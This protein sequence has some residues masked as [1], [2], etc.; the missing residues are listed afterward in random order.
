MRG[1]GRAEQ[2]GQFAAARGAHHPQP[3]GADAGLS[4]EPVQGG[5]EVFERDVDELPWQWVDAEVRERQGGDAVTRQ[6]RGRRRTRQSP[7]GPREE[8]HGGV[9]P[10]PGRA[11][12]LSHQPALA[13]I[14]DG[15]AVG[16]LEPLQHR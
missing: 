12:E 15:D 14:L 6:Q 1:K 9:R 11:V 16:H 13:D 4:R 7:T 3:V 10:G 8:E 2:Q 5:V